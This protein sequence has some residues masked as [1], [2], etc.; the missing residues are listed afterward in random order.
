MINYLAFSASA[1]LIFWTCWFLVRV[2]LQD[3]LWVTGCLH[4]HSYLLDAISNSIPIHDNQ[5]CFQTL[6][7][8]PW[9]VEITLVGRHWI[10][11]QNQVNSVY[12]QKPEKN[13]HNRNKLTGAFPLVEAMKKVIFFF[14]VVYLCTFFLNNQKKFPKTT[15]ILFTYLVLFKFKLVNI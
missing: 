13:Y 1:L 8:V 10:L 14:K 12:P 11:N 9:R 5:K 2:D 15:D 7:N 6:P 3:V 4:Q